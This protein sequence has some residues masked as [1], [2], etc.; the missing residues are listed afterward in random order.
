MSLRYMFLA[1]L[2]LFAVGV[3]APAQADFHYVS[4]TGT[5]SASCS[6]TAPC[7]TMNRALF[8]AQPNDTIVCVDGGI[9]LSLQI[10]KSIDIDCS[11]SRAFIRDN[12]QNNAAIEINIP[13]SASDPF[14]TVRLRGISILGAVATSRFISVGI[15]IISAA[16]V[17]IEDCVIS[18]VAQQG[19]F[20][21]RTGGQTKLFITDSIIR[22]NGGPGIVAA[23]A[24][25][26]IVALDNVRSE[27]N[28]YGI[29]V[30]TGNNVSINRS[31]FSGNTNAGVE[32]DAGA[33]VVVD[34]STITHNN[35]GVQSGSSVRISNNNIAFN[36]T[37]ISGTSGTFGNNRFS[38]NGTI[39]T[40]PTPLGGASSDLG[41]Q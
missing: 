6:P 19:I 23:A 11:G 5:D 22:N 3:D 33:Q 38:G 30:A 21:H 4:S 14:R 36:N 17:S 39:G 37:A 18:D 16:V 32:G 13:V 12:T 40:A 10:F 8:N 2:L 26:G 20:D 25:T 7:L 9:G 31:Q 28:L 1:I 15:N 29:A 41:Q 35:I 27:N 34:N 24:A